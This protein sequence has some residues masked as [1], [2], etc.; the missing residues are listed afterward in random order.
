MATVR[1][2]RGRIPVFR[3]WQRVL[4]VITVSTVISGAVATVSPTPA[5]AYGKAT[6]QAAL[7]GTFTY[8]TTGS[9]FGFW[10]WCDFAGGVTSGDDADCEIAEYVHS[11]AGSGWTCEL[12]LDA[13]SWDESVGDFFPFATFHMTG[14]AVVRPARLP[15]DEKEACLELLGSFT[16]TSFTNL[17]TFIPAAP[18]HYDFG[19]FPGSVGEF[20]FTV[21]QIPQR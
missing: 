9:G 14:S 7:T 3:S 4:L 11:P 19:V 8:P 2:R 17:D 13:T 5:L 21:K 20:N 1:N 6:W 10:G 18:G 16:G 15:A 12:S